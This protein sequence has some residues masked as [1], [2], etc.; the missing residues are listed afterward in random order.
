MQIEKLAW[1]QVILS[2]VGPTCNT[3][4]SKAGWIHGL[5]LMNQQFESSEGRPICN[6]LERD[7]PRSVKRRRF[8]QLQ[9]KN[10]NNKTLAPLHFFGSFYSRFLTEG[11]PNPNYLDEGLRKDI[12][13]PSCTCKMLISKIIFNIK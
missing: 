6:Y 1:F 10:N 13:L 7:C 9:R 12:L 3:C 2:L 4:L 8:T 11:N 5:V